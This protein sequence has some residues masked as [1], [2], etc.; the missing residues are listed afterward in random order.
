[1][2]YDQSIER[3]YGYWHLW[4]ILNYVGFLIKNLRSKYC[5]GQLITL[6][7]NWGTQVRYRLG[8]SK[9][10]LYRGYLKEKDQ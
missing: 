4:S 3:V 5:V 6:G 9:K 8:Y 1:M 10:L 7:T 2:N